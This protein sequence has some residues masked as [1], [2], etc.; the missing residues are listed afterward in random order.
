MFRA[1]L[2]QDDIDECLE[3]KLQGSVTI[4]ESEYEIVS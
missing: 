1:F 3:K 2:Q 4:C